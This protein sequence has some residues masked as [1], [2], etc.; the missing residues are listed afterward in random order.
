MLQAGGDL[1][2]EIFIDKRQ[3]PTGHSYT[4]N[5]LSRRCTS[6]GTDG[7]TTRPPKRKQRTRPSCTSSAAGRPHKTRIPSGSPLSPRRALPTGRPSP[8]A[9]RQHVPL[10]PLPA[11]LRA[12]IEGRDQGLRGEQSRQLRMLVCDVDGGADGGG[13]SA[14]HSASSPV[15][16]PAASVPSPPTFAPSPPTRPPLP[17]HPSSVP[18]PLLPGEVEAEAEAEAEAE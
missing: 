11:Q 5:S 3:N 12:L 8:S 6:S 1:D 9:G 17:P 2:T 4:S 18:S 16:P 14:P 10:Q 15:S 13:D 7:E